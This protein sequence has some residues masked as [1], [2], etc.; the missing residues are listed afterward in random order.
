MLNEPTMD[1][2]KTLALHAMAQAWSEQQA[3]SDMGQVSFDE[4]FGL[5]VDAC[6]RSRRSA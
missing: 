1:K 6:R 4:R 3:R 2:L 5:L